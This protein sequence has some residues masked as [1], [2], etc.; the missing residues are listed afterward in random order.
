MD[1]GYSGSHRYR[2]NITYRSLRKSAA[3]MMSNI[4]KKLSHA[5]QSVRSRRVLHPLNESYSSSPK[6]ARVRVVIPQLS[7]EKNV[8]STTNGKPELEGYKFDSESNILQ[9]PEPAETPRFHRRKIEKS[10]RLRAFGLRCAFKSPAPSACRSA[11]GRS[12]KQKAVL[13]IREI[14]SPK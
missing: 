9:T 10:A 12:A 1:S 14:Q 4:K 8:Y 13:K 2:K 5:E 7:D 3:Q 11:V 6:S